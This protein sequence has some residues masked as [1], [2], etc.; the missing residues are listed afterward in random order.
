MGRKLIDLTG[1]KLNRLYV[2]ERAPNKGTVTMY[3]CKCDCGKIVVVQSG[4]LKNGQI[5]CGCHMKEV[6][7]SKEFSEKS[8]RHG[9]HKHELY[10][11]WMGMKRRCNNPK[12]SSYKNYG[13]RGIKVCDEW[14]GDSPEQYI[15]DIEEK[16]GKRPKNHT[17]DRINN[18]GNYEI[19][20]VRWA[21]KS[22]Q[23]VNQRHKEGKLKEKYIIY[24]RGLYLVSIFRNKKGMFSNG[25]KELKDAIFLRDY[26]LKVYNETPHKWEEMCNNKKYKNIIGEMTNGK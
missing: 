6:Y 4:N 19:D 21:S 1:K 16:L 26:Y 5:S 15:K 13:G 7:A 24:R 10:S 17:L 14:N 8:T 2:I 18:D 20:N 3:R 22:E 12:D 11:S 9:Y 23:T 25:Q